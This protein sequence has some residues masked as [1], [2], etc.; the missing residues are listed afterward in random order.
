MCACAAASGHVLQCSKGNFSLWPSATSTAASLAMHSVLPHMAAMCR[1]CDATKRIERRC[2]R[3]ISVQ[4][5]KKKGAESGELVR[6]DLVRETHVV[7]RRATARHALIL[8]SDSMCA[9]REGD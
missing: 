5:K 1:G 4:N 2:V 3:S 7:P 8:R 9:M 6:Q